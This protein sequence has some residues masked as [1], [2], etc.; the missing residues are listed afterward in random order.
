MS[1][2]ACPTK[3]DAELTGTVDRIIYRNGDDSYCVFLLNGDSVAGPA[4]GIIAG[5]KIKAIGTWSNHPKYGRQFKLQWFERIVSGDIG[6]AVAYLSSGLIKGVGPALA[7]RIVEK[8]GENA[9]ELIQ[10][11][12][13]IKHLAKVRGISA[14]K[15]AVIVQS[16]AETFCQQHLVSHIIRYGGTPLLAAKA[17]AQWGKDAL[18]KITDNPYVLTELPRVGFSIADRI[19]LAMGYARDG[20]FRMRAGLI[21]VLS[22]DRS[23]HCLLPRSEAVETAATILDVP[24]PAVDAVIQPMIQRNLICEHNGFLQ[25]TRLAKAEATVAAVVQKLKNSNRIDTSHAPAAIARFEKESNMVLTVKQREAV[26]DILSH[27]IFIL[28]GGP[29]TGKTTT[30]K[31]VVGVAKQ[32]FP[33]WDIALCAPTGR[34]SRRLAEV[35]SQPAFT[36]HRLLGLR[37]DDSEP[38]KIEAD[39]IIVDEFSMVDICLAAKL[40]TALRLGARLLLVGDPDQLPSVRPG[41]VLRDLI[42]CVPNLHLTDILRQAEQSQIIVNAHALNMGISRIEAGRDFHFYEGNTPEAMHD[43]IISIVRTYHKKYGSIDPVQVLSPMKKGPVG[44]N[45]LNTSIQA[46]VNPPGPPELKKHVIF[47]LGDR[48]IQLENDYV[49]NVFNGDTGKI[50]AVNTEDAVLTVDFPLSGKVDYPIA[51]TD[52]LSLAYAVTVHKSQG[53]EYPVVIVPATNS[54][55]IMLARNLFYTA[56]TRAQRHLVLVGERRAYAIAAANNKVVKRYTRLTELV[57]SKKQITKA[58]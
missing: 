49:K 14:T 37:D 30:M 22:E 39:L 33:S 7:E 57:M 43:Q 4:P 3:P 16:V 23:G 6:A 41:N 34:A 29:G 58:Q 56:I 54:H 47:R 1:K 32:L 40:F 52:V 2:T 24:W 48:V 15:A 42:A 9:V 21:H 11:P 53:S 46:A 12:D 5:E 55:Y 10:S 38:Q 13:G 20:E 51:E 27:R 18:T 45:A 19:G 36:I 25:I 35:A 26:A 44:V 50:I 28:T 17:I 31:A 8:L